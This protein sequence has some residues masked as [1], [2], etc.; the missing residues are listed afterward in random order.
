MGNVSK[1]NLLPTLDLQ[2]SATTV[3]G[4]DCRPTAADV[5]PN[6]KTGVEYWAKHETS[7]VALVPSSPISLS[8]SE[9]PFC[10]VCGRNAACLET[11]TLRD[12]ERWYIGRVIETCGSL[13]T[14]AATLGINYSTLWRKR[15]RYKML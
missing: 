2:L 9:G 6:E 8:Q 13:S 12:L 10:R 15:K 7:E 3:P 14:A 5:C 11:V 4:L 1:L